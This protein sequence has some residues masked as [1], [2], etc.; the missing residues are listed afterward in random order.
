MEVLLAWCCLQ[1][2]VTGQRGSP[3]SRT[4]MVRALQPAFEMRVFCDYS[5][6]QA[7]VLTS[8]ARSRLR[9]WLQPVFQAW[10]RLQAKMM[11]FRAVRRPTA[12]QARSLSPRALATAPPMD[13]SVR[14]PPKVPLALPQC[15]LGPAEADLSSR[16]R[17]LPV[18]ATV[19]SPL[20]RARPAARLLLVEAA[21]GVWQPFSP[22]TAGA[23]VRPKLWARRAPLAEAPSAELR[24]VP[25]AALRRQA[26]PGAPS[27][28][29]A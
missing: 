1:A 27:L 5:V 14:S 13:C 10:R 22:P 15:R 17:A 6:L 9:A 23:R 4:L 11:V 28:L 24:Q 16:A 8:A 18:A 3:Q 2:Q 21:F 20:R 29:P 26:E 7:T 19:V 12:M 25:T